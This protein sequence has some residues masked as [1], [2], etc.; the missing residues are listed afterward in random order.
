MSYTS[1]DGEATDRSAD[2][3]RAAGIEVLFEM[4]EF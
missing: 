3:T 1:E 4:S 2:G